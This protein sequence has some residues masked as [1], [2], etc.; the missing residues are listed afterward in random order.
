[1]GNRKDPWPPPQPIAPSGRLAGW[2]VAGCLFVAG[3]AT[4]LL[5]WNEL[6]CGIVIDPERT[7]VDPDQICEVLTGIGGLAVIVGIVAIVGGALIARDVRGREVKATGSDAWRWGLAI[8]FTIGVMVLAT[9]FP[10]QTC[11]GEAHL[12]G[13][14]RMCIDLE[15]SLRY[16]STSWIWAKSLVALAAPVIGFAVIPRRKLIT[17]TAPL[18]AAAW[19]AGIGWLLLDTLGREL[20]V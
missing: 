17:V 8:V 19:A 20:R 5:A 4:V 9:R 16:D 14:F 2:T 3:L 10:S 11:P 12:S 7:Q 13:P 15:Q 6:R 18:T 1:M